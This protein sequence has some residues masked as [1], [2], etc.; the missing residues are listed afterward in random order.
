METKIFKLNKW[1][2]LLIL[3]VS[4]IF[5]MNGLTILFEGKTEVVSTSP[6]LVKTVGFLTLLIFGIMIY[7]ASKKL[8]DPELGITLNEEGINDH[9]SSLAVGM[10]N[11]ANITQIETKKFLWLKSLAI[12]TNNPEKYLREASGIKLR[13]L[14]GNLNRTETPV[15][16]TAG[17][18]KIKF[19]KLE[20]LIQDYW[21]KSQIQNL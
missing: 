3:L 4:V 21:E 5:I 10:V 17:S 2:L 1:R 19:A 18:L 15:L 20:E 13:I 7:I 11:W 16:I 6:F 12:H 8:F 9:S 14:A